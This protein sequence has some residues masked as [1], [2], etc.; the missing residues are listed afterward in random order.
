MDTVI[1]AAR[2][3]PGLRRGAGA[4]RD[5]RTLASLGTEHAITV[6][7][8]LDGGDE[9]SG[10]EPPAQGRIALIDML[11]RLY[12]ATPLARRT[13][14]VRRPDLTARPALEAAFGELSHPWHGGP[15]SEPWPS[16]QRPSGERPSGE[17][18]SGERPSGER[19][20]GERP[21]GE[22]PSGQPC[23]SGQN[24]GLLACELLGRDDTPVAQVGEL[25]QLVR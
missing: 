17:R 5:G 13:A 18:P 14:P 15:Y 6:F 24:L 23:R 12:N 25:G 16:G 21:S 20:S 9:N 1:A 8:Y 7:P 11:A 3:G 4:G 10:G 2:G 19:P 22:R